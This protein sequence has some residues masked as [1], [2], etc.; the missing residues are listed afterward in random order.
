[1]F[2]A[3]KTEQEIKN[4]LIAFIL[5]W[6]K[7]K[8]NDIRE[9][10]R[11]LWSSPTPGQ[12][13]L[14]SDLLIENNFSYIMSNPPANLETINPKFF[15]GLLEQLHFREEVIQQNSLPLL[16]NHQPY[17]GGNPKLQEAFLSVLRSNTFSSSTTLFVHQE[18]AIQTAI[19]GKDFI[20]SSGTGSGK[21]EAF[22]LPALARVFNESDE[23]RKQPGIRIL[24]IY[25]MNALINS[26]ITRIQ[27]LIGVQDP[28]RVPI[29]FALYNSKLKDDQ[30]R[31]S[32]Y[33]N[34]VDDY[35]HWPDLQTINR[36]DLR[37]E[38]PHILVTNYSMLEYALIRPKDFILF[39]PERQKLHTIILDEAHTYIG[40]MA[41]EIAMLIRRVLLAF[42]KQSSEVQFFATSATLG[43]PEKDEGFLLRKFA[44][45]LF[46][47]E[48]SMI[49]Y[50]GGKRIKPLTF[51]KHK[52]PI[53]TDNILQ[54]LIQLETLGDQASDQERVELI[55]EH[56]PSI[57][58][59]SFPDA[60]YQVFI[61]DQV[62]VNLVNDLIKTPITVSTLASELG[63][64]S[65][66]HLAY[67]VVK[68]LSIITSDTKTKPL[69]KLRLH[70]VVEAPDGVFY[71]RICRTYYGTY[72]D[73]CPNASCNQE[74]LME[75]VVCKQC[76][77]AYLCSSKNKEGKVQ[78]INWR[79]RNYSIPLQI[80]TI[81]GKPAELQACS[82]CKNSSDTHPSEDLKEQSAT[83]EFDTYVID[84]EIALYKQV[85]FSAISV[86]ID[87]VQ[88]IAI[89]TLY[90]NLDPHPDS[91][92]TWLPGGGRRLLTFTDNRQGAA[93]LPT[94]LDW[95]HEIYLG[96]RLLIEA[97][98]SAIEEK[99][100][101]QEDQFFSFSEIGNMWLDMN[102]TMR[103][104]L[105]D[106]MDTM[107]NITEVSV[108]KA[109]DDQL[110][111]FPNSLIFPRMY[112]KL[113]LIKDILTCQNPTHGITFSEAQQA[114]S[115]H[116]DLREMV[117]IFEKINKCNSWEDH[118]YSYKI[119]YWIL[120]RSLGI[121]ST[122]Q[123]LPENSGLFKLEFNLPVAFLDGLQQI[124][125]LN[126]YSHDQLKA[127]VSGLLNHMRNNGCISVPNPIEEDIKAAAKYSLQNALINQYMVVERSMVPK[128]AERYI[129]SWYNLKTKSETAPIRIVRKAL[130]NDTI[131]IGTCQNIIA[132]LWPHL[133]E[134]LP[135]YFSMH[136]K[137]TNA[138]ALKLDAAYITM[139]PRMYHCPI[140][141]RNTPHHINGNCITSACTGKITVLEQ[142]KVEDLYGYKRSLHFPKLGMSTV[143]HTAQLDLSEL[144]KNEKQ[145][146][147]G[148]VNVLSSSTTMELGIDI[149]GITSIVLTNCPP[150]PSNYLQRAGRAGRRADRTAYV[151]TS[152]R[153]VPLDHYF[154]L[155]PDLFFIR[156]PHDPYVSLN[157]EKVVKRH[158]NSYILREFFNYLTET[159]EALRI[160]ITKSSNPLA[161]YGTV[162]DFFGFES[163]SLL[164]HPIINYLLDWLKQLSTLQGF[165]FL[166]ENTQLGIGFNKQAY[167]LE[168]YDFFKEEHEQL[169]AYVLEIH[170]EVVKENSNQKRQ[171][172][173][174]YYLNNLRNTDI[175]SF[176]I[177]LSFLPK[178]G[179]PTNVISL[180]TQ[181]WR[182]FVKDDDNASQK[183][184]FRLQRSSE[185]AIREY[186]PGEQL[187]AGKRLLTSKGIS[188]D[189]RLGGE[190][191]STD[192]SKLDRRGFVECTTCKHF[193]IVPP[194]VEDM[195]CPVCGTPA[196]RKTPITDD[197]SL[198]DPTNT[199]RYGLLP[200]GFRVDYKEEQPYAP[201]KIDKDYPFSITYAALQ[202][203]KE[204]FI[205]IVPEIL[206]VASTQSAIF[207]T[208]NKGPDRRG[209]AICTSCGRSESEFRY[210]LESMKNHTRLYSDKPCK[211]QEP[212]RGQ[213][214]MA[215]FI[216]DAIQIRFSSETIPLLKNP[217]E[218]QLFIQ[219][220]ARCLQFAAA[221]FLGIDDRE[222]KFL[223]QSYWDQ[224]SGNWNN[225]EIVLYDNVPG[226]AGYAEMI[227]H[228]FGHPKFF[229]YLL[230]ATECPEQ[231]TSACPACLITYEKEDSEQNPYNRHL[232]R[233][234]LERADIHSFFTSYIGTI[235]PSAGDHTVYNI[236]KDLNS[237]LM[238]K[239][240]GKAMLYFNSL[241]ED[242]FMIV[243]G[244]FGILL[245]LA[246]KGIEITLVFPSALILK[247][248]T[249]EQQ[250]LR[251]GLS[252]AGENLQLRVRDTTSTYS[253]AAVVDTG[254]HIFLYENFHSK[255]ESI[256]PFSAFPCIRKQAVEDY[257][258]P[259]H[260][261]TLK[262][263]ESY[264]GIRSLK[265]EFK[266][267]TSIE[268][269]RLWKYICE[270]FDLDETKTIETIWYSDRYLLRYV[271]NICFLM[272]LDDMP[273]LQGATINIAVHGGK[274]SY[275][276]FSFQD[277]DSQLRFFQ[278][279]LDLNKSKTTI[280]MFATTEHVQNDDPGQ[281]HQRELL[282]C[283]A[284][285]SNTLF[286]FDSGMSF[287]SPY[288][289][290]YWSI[291]KESY[292][293]MILKMEKD[294]HKYAKFM[295][296]I[297]F[298][299]PDQEI[300]TLLDITFK[301]AISNRRIRLV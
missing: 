48:L 159:E 91:T 70:S 212:L 194:T 42:N 251:Y 150:G 226:G 208:I 92:N 44:S 174:S 116:P 8:D 169:K 34:E 232:V 45:D 167:F 32:A 264:Q 199:I 218:S 61:R 268:Q 158:L 134:S 200:K 30:S 67:L 76:G 233:Q 235:V 191:F 211:N 163:I 283:Y 49:D 95:L 260:V 295:D 46:S 249:Q 296:S 185:I 105:I 11:K 301:Q 193:Y 28:T 22:L 121:L 111:K 23:E 255:A 85:F 143:E 165:D 179:F 219:T 189:S 72:H 299:Y 119:A 272:L 14:L 88:K 173:L 123:Y 287:F 2:D 204:A 262:L 290:R 275:S 188:L 153:K 94:A 229:S 9:A 4:N 223:I 148:T 269:V 205:Q 55:L 214:L 225:Q 293:Q 124:P 125:A 6:K 136:E 120:V 196:Y 245:E 277:R 273:L 184:R 261:S 99:N 155:H 284:D 1:M 257:K 186:A 183:N 280:K 259:I 104:V 103:P 197:G 271:E 31:F 227:L 286:S 180:N 250:N 177:N 107:Q 198:T 222:L 13:S 241:P 62:I 53:P 247:D 3:Y 248:Y 144:T 38:P 131:P 297:I 300:S 149:G 228:L 256:T 21:T 18:Q 106:L 291:E 176:F 276:D 7:I 243:G 237:L 77:E 274:T 215:E 128:D 141:N 240:S 115:I 132:T 102:P 242:G 137:V 81:E 101:K 98:K 238:G 129:K 25:P 164:P 113:D 64:P 210:T 60:L 89:D 20:L 147:E 292:K 156:K 66:R 294:Y 87:L 10:L 175:V 56:F 35:S 213:S 171:K 54:L 168:L 289:D 202:T 15:A 288:L 160:Q 231:C 178:Y 109:L 190:S 270:Q 100:K 206:Q 282:V 139:L 84:P 278:A 130:G 12:G 69:V 266:Q 239:Q 166:L 79:G 133:I 263:D 138:Y 39:H 78:R 252:Y 40:A 172:A 192:S 74:P 75:L 135:Q 244:E 161:S 86:S 203:S 207:Y 117:G 51:V 187:I 59:S 27:S 298:K 217:Q 281:R 221:K 29:R 65:K 151:L 90:E 234:F 96:N 195:P 126:I 112:Q 47:K 157:S 265:T 224:E 63:V 71:C 230:E 118:A 16:S 279:Q 110:E 36:E 170:E 58:P 236:V 209:Y 82:N 43:D 50:I 93:K 127:L 122:S 5:D 140:C 57:A 253:C 246:K 181:N 26:Q 37:K 73:H 80:T 146:T 19:K 162:K 154:F 145:F 216:T 201:N 33:K 142:K 68:Y 97:V 83:Q 152:A 285:G 258:F 24:I 17:F 220:F 267:I 108:T 182:A 254:T 114:L 52:K 41:A